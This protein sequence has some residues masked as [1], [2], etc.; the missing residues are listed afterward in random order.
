MPSH[1]LEIEAGRWIKPNSIPLENRKCSVC[2]RLEDEYHF[3]LE[4]QIY[5]E[6]RKTYI[7]LYFW[8]KKTNMFKFIEL[9]YTTNHNYLRKLCVYIFHA[10][11]LRTDKLYSNP[12]RN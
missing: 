2:L 7:S 11:K 6:L 9:I 1:R 5:V 12:L 4:C 3:V 10:F 8:K